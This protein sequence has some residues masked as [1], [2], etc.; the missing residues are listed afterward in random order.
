MSKT[1]QSQFGAKVAWEI[2]KRGWSREKAAYELGVDQKTIQ[3]WINDPTE[4]PST[5]SIEAL[6]RVFGF[7][8][9][10]I[11]LSLGIQIPPIESTREKFTALSFGQAADR[12]GSMNAVVDACNDVASEFPVPAEED[13]YG[14]YEQWL[15]LMEVSPD[16]GGTIADSDGYA[17]GYWHAVAVKD[18]IYRDI[19]SGKNVNKSIS[20][21]D[22]EILV[23][24][25]EYNLY[26]VDLFIRRSHANVPTRRMIKDSFLSFMRSAAMA[27]IFFNKIAAN[28]TGPEV[29][30][31]CKG[32][33]FQKVVDH[34]V[35]RYIDKGGTIVCAQIFELDMTK[36]AERLFLHSDDLRRLYSNR[37]SSR[38]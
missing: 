19:L 18:K 4:K 1:K 7:T 20:A 35:H 6:I 26:F 24:S 29:M 32:L 10:E 12:L 11:L 31:L 13:E 30:R 36:D 8:R 33:G 15:E 3:R 21:D 17:I 38:R 34:S 14:S 9:P 2:K 25:G 28:V 5:G 37:G 16:S 22:V 23:D 27:G